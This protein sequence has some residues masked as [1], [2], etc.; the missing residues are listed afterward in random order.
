MVSREKL[1]A[2]KKHRKNPVIKKKIND[3]AKKYREKNRKKLNEAMVIRKRNRRLYILEIIGGSKCA[4]CRF[5]DVRALQID[6]I[7]GGGNKERDL[8]KSH[9]AY[10]TNVLKNPKKYQILC[11]NCNWIKRYESK[12]CDWKKWI[13]KK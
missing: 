10:L 2:L 1:D 13:I 7:N 3:Y 5:S 9:F 8:A 11:A 12:E 6:H 4:K